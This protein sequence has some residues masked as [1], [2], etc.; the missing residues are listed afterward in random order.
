[1]KPL[2]KLNRYA[3]IVAGG[4]GNRMGL[5]VPKQFLPLC[6][7]PVLIHTLK[8]FSSLSQKPSIYLV[9]PISEHN[10]WKDLCKKHSF[11]VPHTLVAG[12]ETRFHSV[13]NGLD[14][15]EGDG[16][17]AIHDGVRPLV[18]QELVEKCYLMAQN[19]GNAVPAVNPFESIRVGK[20]NHNRKE[21]RDLIW[22]V[23]TPQVFSVSQAQ[24]FYKVEWNQEYTDDSSVAEANG[25]IINLLEG[26]RDNIK[27][28]TPIDLKIAEAILESR[29]K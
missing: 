3:I 9:L 1:M 19:A 13:K 17:V 23:Q 28:T 5:S 26:S 10:A 6:G 4:S 16:L 12:G 18:T 8:V 2:M 20:V 27:I 15:I 22:L 11:N 21:N 14:S 29:K 7:V 24:E 25:I